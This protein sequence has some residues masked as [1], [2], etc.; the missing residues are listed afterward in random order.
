[1]DFT[2]SD[3]QQMI[4]DTVRSFLENELYSYEEEV[5]RSGVVPRELGQE[6][7]D[8]CKE[9]GFFAPNISSESGGGGLN[10]LEFSLLERELGR[11]SMA[12]TVY[13]GRPSVRIVFE[14]RC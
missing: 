2:L 10:Q 12:L 14:N 5:E 4:V 9:T 11:A 13:F 6:I 8:K 3:E 1:M 7:A